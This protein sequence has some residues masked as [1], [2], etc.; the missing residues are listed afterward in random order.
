MRAAR[1]PF[2][3]GWVIVAVAFVMMRVSVNARTAFSLFLPPLIDT[4][5]SYAPAF[6]V[7]IGVSGLS[8]LAIW[9]AAPRKVQAVAG[10]I[11]RLDSPA[12]TR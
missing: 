2:F 11:H 7:A 4:T 1:L 9:L 6:L 12:S 3:Y 5:A 10:R 8:A